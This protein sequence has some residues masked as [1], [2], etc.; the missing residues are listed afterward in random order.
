MENRMETAGWWQAG[1][2]LPWALK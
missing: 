2:A 1:Q